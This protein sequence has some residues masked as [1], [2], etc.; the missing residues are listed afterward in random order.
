MK[1]LSASASTMEAQAQL[2]A[3]S[4]HAL[5]PAAAAGAGPSSHKVAAT[6]PLLFGSTASEG[7]DAVRRRSQ[8]VNALSS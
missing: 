6:A 5:H 1:S 7:V 8:I 2:Y 3:N 4:W